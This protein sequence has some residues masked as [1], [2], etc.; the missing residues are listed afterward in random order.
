MNHAP[1]SG[2]RDRALG[3]EPWYDGY[4]SSSPQERARLRDA[5]ESLVAAGDRRCWYASNLL[6]VGPV[7][8]DRLSRLASL[9]LDRSFEDGSTVSFISEGAVQPA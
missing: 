8:S 4:V 5:A 3:C 6:S 1:E 9:Y 7:E 2:G